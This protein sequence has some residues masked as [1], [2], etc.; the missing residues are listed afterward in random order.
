MSHKQ[1]RGI[2]RTQGVDPG[3]DPCFDPGLDPCLA[4]CLDHAIDQHIG[5]CRSSK[6]GCIT[7]AK[8]YN[9]HIAGVGSFIHHM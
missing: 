1:A 2:I 5:M 8:C 3:L 4:P 6:T 7:P 9:I